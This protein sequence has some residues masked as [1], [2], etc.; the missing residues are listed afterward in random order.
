MVNRSLK[1]RPPDCYLTGQSHGPDTPPPFFAFSLSV[2]SH[3]EE[4]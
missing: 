2:T 4:M 1:C 3:E